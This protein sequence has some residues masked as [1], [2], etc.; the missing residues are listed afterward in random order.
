MLP[1]PFA[2]RL[3]RLSVYD[4]HALTDMTAARFLSNF[5]AGM[6]PWRNLRYTSSALQRYLLRSDATLYCYA[7]V[8]DKMIGVVCVRYPW[9]R[10]ACLELIS[11]DTAES[12]AGS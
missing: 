1:S 5:L 2:A 10:G 8:Q 9:L 12:D 6:D 3:Y 11:L 7:V 4:L